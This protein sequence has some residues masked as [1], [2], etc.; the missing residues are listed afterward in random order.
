M[1]VLYARF[2]TI[3]L[4]CSSGKAGIITK[5]ESTPTVVAVNRH[6][7]DCAA[8]SVFGRFDMVATIVNI[9]NPLVGIYSLGVSNM[10]LIYELN[11]D[12]IL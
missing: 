11:M 6:P 3:W 12:K 7:G 8:S 2:S 9:I 10:Q 5:T 1:E 4:P